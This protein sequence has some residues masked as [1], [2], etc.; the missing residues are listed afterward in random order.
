MKPT[1]LWMLSQGFNISEAEGKEAFEGGYAMD[2]HGY[3]ESVSG[4][5]FERG[6]KSAEARSKEQRA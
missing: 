5:D 6:W 4:A 3:G 2:S 1:P